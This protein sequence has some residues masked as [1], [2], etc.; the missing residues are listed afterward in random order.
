MNNPFIV[1]KE[2]MEELSEQSGRKLNRTDVVFTLRQ[3]ANN[4]NI[5]STID[6]IQYFKDPKTGAMKR[7]TPKKK[8]GR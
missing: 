7:I 2:K 3:D 5:F 1:T 4:K 6:G 8:K